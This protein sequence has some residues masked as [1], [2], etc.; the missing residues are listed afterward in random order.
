MR[1]WA[2]GSWGGKQKR[3]FFLVRTLCDWMNLA[4]A[5][6]IAVECDEEL[7]T[8]APH[9]NEGSLRNLSAT[10]PY[11]FVALYGSP[12]VANR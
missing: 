7:T 10:E 4:V 11:V 9:E 1:S 3:V 6:A 5:S 8:V 2:D 12:V